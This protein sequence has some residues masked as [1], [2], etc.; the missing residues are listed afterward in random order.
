[1]NALSFLL[2]HQRESWG[3]LRAGLF[4]F[5]DNGYDGMVTILEACSWE[6]LT[7]GMICYVLMGRIC[8]PRCTY[9]DSAR[10]VGVFWI[11]V[12]SFHYRMIHFFSPGCVVV[13]ALHSPCHSSPVT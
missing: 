12:G 9:W 7:Q 4:C 2:N 10:Y 1:M 6:L 11:K 5:F 13:I 8:F 3:S